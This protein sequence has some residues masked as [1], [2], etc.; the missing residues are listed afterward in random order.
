MAT[1]S[2]LCF[3]CKMRMHTHTTLLAV[4]GTGIRSPAIILHNV[5]FYSRTICWSRLAELWPGLETS[6]GVESRKV[7]QPFRW[8]SGDVSRCWAVQQIPAEGLFD[9]YKMEL[10]LT[11][12]WFRCLREEVILS[13][14]KEVLILHKW[15]LFSFLLFQKCFIK[16]FCKDLNYFSWH[17]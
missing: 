10:N 1:C 9:C 8:C 13:A 7:Q 14:R 15:F 4:P 5:S 6:V 3:L 12:E 2:F 17:K 11:Q 16:L